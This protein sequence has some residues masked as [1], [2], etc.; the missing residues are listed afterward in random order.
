[1]NSRDFLD[2]LIA[3]RGHLPDVEALPGAF[4][5]RLV[6]KYTHELRPLLSELSKLPKEDQSSFIKALALYEQTVGGIG[7]PS[8]LFGA[9]PKVHDPDHK[10]F[11]WVLTHTNSY[12]YYSHGAKSFDEMQRI[13]EIS[14]ARSAANL[15]QEV[16]RAKD[17]AIRRAEKATSN[18]F[19]AIRRGDIQAV[20]A[21]LNQGASREA[22]DPS[23]LDAISYADHLDRKEI[24]QL[25]RGQIDPT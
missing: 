8:L 23:G 11:D 16:Q 6:L 22:T 4:N 14:R 18:L 20:T 12:E 2:L 13:E 15:E 9:L 1:V 17:A 7:S 24:A 25:L 3:T 10:L 19:N 5:H 21:L